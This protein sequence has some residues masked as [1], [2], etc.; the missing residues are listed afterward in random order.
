M[1]PNV[2]LKLSKRA[3]E[4]LFGKAI[5]NIGRVLYSS[6][7]T[8]YTLLVAA[9]RRSVLKAYDNYVNINDFKD[10]KKREQISTKYKKSYFNYIITLERVITEN[11]YTK[12]QKRA[13]TVDEETIMSKYYEVN[14]FKGHDDVEHRIRLEI[15]C[16][17]MDW[18]NV[19]A[20][21]SETLLERFKAFY[22]YN[23]KELYKG[24]M[25]HDAILLANAKDGDRDQYEAVYSII[26]QYIK[27][28]LPILEENETNNRIIKDYKRYVSSVDS[29]E[30]KSYVE[31]RKRL[32]LLGFAGDLFEFSL[33]NVAKEQCYLEIIEIARILVTNEHTEADKYSA[34]EVLLDGIEEY[35]DNILAKK[36][37][38]PIIEEKREY[39]ALNEKW[40]E[41]KKLAR[42]DFD[43][44]KRKRE[45]LFIRYDSGVMKRKK[46]NLPELKDYYHERLVILHEL[47][48]LKSKAK[49]CN[50]V[51]RSRRRMKVDDFNETINEKLREPL[52]YTNELGTYTVDL[53]VVDKIY[54]Y[55]IVE[56][57]DIKEAED[58]QKKAEKERN[59]I[60][61]ASFIIGKQGRFVKRKAY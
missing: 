43:C 21:K 47:K 28:V 50:K 25:R 16:L 41:L 3:D 10:E 11:I 19:Q 39:E 9:R 45:V 35:I 13:A 14:K 36:T 20:H 59:M 26:D 32:A 54:E 38:W 60:N 31:L 40:Q 15:L 42:I 27:E 18:E 23:I 6:N 58:K 51:L 2:S 29:F 22:L 49:L 5:S 53:D 24:Q 57:H 12:M 17:N 48:N 34:F 1:D 30:Q 46:V 33:P 37:Y 7:F 61:I 56:E 44:F 4:T 8:I 52:R 55:K